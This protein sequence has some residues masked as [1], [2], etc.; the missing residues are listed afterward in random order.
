M[1]PLPLLSTDIK[2]LISSSGSPKN[3]SAPWFS[4]AIKLLRITPIL[5]VVILPYVVIYSFLFSPI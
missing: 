2:S 4:S 5:W 3:L 1:I